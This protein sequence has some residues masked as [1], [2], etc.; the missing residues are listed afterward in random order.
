MHPI[1]LRGCW[2]QSATRNGSGNGGATLL[3]F[4]KMVWLILFLSNHVEIVV[5]PPAL[6]N[7]DPKTLSGA[8][9]S[10][11][12]RLKRQIYHTVCEVVFA[13]LES[14]SRN[15]EAIRFGD[16]VTRIAYPGILV[17]SMDFE[18]M[19]AWL[20]IRNSRAN[21]PC[22]KCLVHHDDLH[23]LSADAEPRTSES[24]HQVFLEATNLPATQREELLKS[25]GLHFFGVRLF[26]PILSTP[27]FTLNSFLFGVSTIPTHILL[28]GT[29]CYITLIAG[30]GG[31]MFGLASRSTFKRRSSRRNSTISR[32]KN[33]CT[34]KKR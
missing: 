22:P 33:R 34:K 13:S 12:D 18:E 28:R 29:I 19:A 30:N 2:I 26:S 7:I 31:S 5:Q 32:S 27:T 25:Y 20:A 4:V 23:K 8:S 3:G 17:E 11:Y 15:G 16:G 24:M 14:R 10:E 9:R 1:L 6:R 21:H